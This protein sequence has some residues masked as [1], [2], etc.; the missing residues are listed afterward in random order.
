MDKNGARLE[1]QRQ[2]A[3]FAAEMVSSKPT[4]VSKDDDPLSII[5]Q[6]DDEP[7]LA[8]AGNTATHTDEVNDMV[9]SADVVF[10]FKSAYYNDSKSYANVS[11][12]TISYVNKSKE[13]IENNED[14]FDIHAF[15]RSIPISHQVNLSGHEKAATCISYEPAGNRVITG[16][17]DYSFRMFDFGGMDARHKPFRALDAQDGYPVSSICH[18]STGDKFIVGTGS[19]QPKV[20]DRDGAEIIKFCRGDMYLRDLSNTKGHTMEVT[21]VAWHPIEK[22][23]MLTSS[24][25][26][27][28]RIWDLFG[29]ANFGCLMNKHVLKVKPVIGGTNQRLG[30]SSCCYS[31]N[32]TRMIGGACDGSIH[33]FNEKKVYNRCDMVIRPGHSPSSMVTSV[34]LLKDDNTLLS[35]GSDDTI[36]VWNLKSFKAPVKVINNTCSIY[37]TANLDVSPDQSLL[38]CGLTT[39]HINND[40]SS[41]NIKSLLCFYDIKGTAITPYLQISLT[42]KNSSN[43]ST[44]LV[45][46]IHVKWQASIN[47]IIVTMSDGSIKAF[48]DPRMSKKGAL[49]TASKAPKRERDVVEDVINPDDIIAPHTLPMY[50]IE[51]SMK[52]KLKDL[53]NPVLNH[54]PQRPIVDTGPRETV[55]SSFTQYIVK[56]K[57]SQMVSADAEDARESI[58]KMDELAKKEPIFFGEA[59]SKTQ[60]KTLLH[61]MTFEEEQ[62][63]FKN[64]QARIL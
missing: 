13:L 20:F 54:V 8:A 34:L 19:C 9:D 15:K 16:S 2:I 50:K 35:R 63:E 22:N 46:P 44:S 40:S 10:D 58:L 24:L 37:P 56:N 7:V 39:G 23:T 64:K 3:A 51:S 57:Q 12:N 21:G 25:D 38:C 28:M 17:L 1:M 59:Y 14:V 4:F 55:T 26:G 60:P 48:Y 33:I 61:T 43:T 29:E 49:L 47:Q 5:Y 6:Y 52:R 45:S 42:N 53:K 32:G 36:K 30:V 18:S 31:H 11:S 41:S 27:T 62:E